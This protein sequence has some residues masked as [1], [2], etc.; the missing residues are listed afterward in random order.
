MSAVAQNCKE[1]PFR[2]ELR[3]LLDFTGP[4]AGRANA[5]APARAIHQRTH[6]LQVQIPTPLRH[7][8]SVTDAVPELGTAATNFANFRHKTEIS[9][10]IEAI[11][12]SMRANARQPTDFLARGLLK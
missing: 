2:N 9:R 3:D 5:Q 10:R 7:I 8:V 4:N 6:R 11:I 12:I 1:M